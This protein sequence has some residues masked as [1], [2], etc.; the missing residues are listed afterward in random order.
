MPAALVEIGFV[1]GAED[2]ARLAITWAQQNRS[3]DRQCNFAICA[4]LKNA[5]VYF[6]IDR[7]H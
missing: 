2:A 5:I 3:S 6:Q 7:C 1:T 4:V